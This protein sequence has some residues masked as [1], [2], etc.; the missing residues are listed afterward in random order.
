MC[1]LSESRAN[2]FGKGLLSLELVHIRSYLDP[3]M[4][5]PQLQCVCREDIGTHGSLRRAN[6]RVVRRL[7]FAIIADITT[8]LHTD[9]ER[10]RLSKTGVFMAADGRLHQNALDPVVRQGP[11]SVV[12]LECGAWQN[13]IR[14]YN[15]GCD[16][17]PVGT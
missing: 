7:C 17:H 10:Q 12:Q 6:P 9:G 13:T 3:S 14:R 8:L 2:R 4:S 11:N 15:S 1:R 16:I 5:R